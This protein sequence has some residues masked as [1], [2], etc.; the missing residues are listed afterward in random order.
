MSKSNHDKYNLSHLKTC[1]GCQSHSMAFVPKDLIG[2]KFN[3]SNPTRKVSFIQAAFKVLLL[4]KSIRSSILTLA[5]KK[6]CQIISEIQQLLLRSLETKQLTIDETF[7]KLST[8]YDRIFIIEDA[9]DALNII[10]NLFH[11]FQECGNQCPFHKHLI[12]EL[13]INSCNYSFGF[14]INSFY[15]LCEINSPTESLFSQYVKQIKNTN[16][17]VCGTKCQKK[18][19]CSLG[20]DAICFKLNICVMNVKYDSV[21]P[22]RIPSTEIF[23]NVD[24]GFFQL[25][26]LITTEQK[27]YLIENGY[28]IDETEN[29]LQ[30]RTFFD[31][32]N[33][34]RI[35]ILGVVY[36]LVNEPR[37]SQVKSQKIPDIHCR[38]GKILDVGETLCRSC[39][40]TVMYGRE[41]VEKKPIT[42]GKIEEEAK[43][44]RKGHGEIQI[45]SKITKSVE[46]KWHT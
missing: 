12:T 42:K 46:K 16:C 36:V 4:H 23:C 32:I 43:I 11:N 19:S 7:T 27:V 34:E 3:H 24:F 35:N 22:S 8:K 39:G 28:I 9:L 10:M 29:Y 17:V 1:E 37:K 14:G 2:I 20:K 45:K 15:K 6:P 5:L 31:L 21:I 33:T 25:F 44:N 26:A 30:L 18:I 38:C 40:A 41:I 13:Y